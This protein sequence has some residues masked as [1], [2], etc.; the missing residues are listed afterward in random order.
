MFFFWKKNCS[1]LAFY[2]RIELLLVISTNISFKNNKL[3]DQF[4]DF[5]DKY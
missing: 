4:D 5:I 3:I 2:Y 1:I